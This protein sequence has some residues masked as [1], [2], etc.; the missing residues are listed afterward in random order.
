MSEIL[1]R[2]GGLPGLSGS[3]EFPPGRCF[4][5]SSPGVLRFHGEAVRRSLSSRQTTELLMEDGEPAKNW[6]TLRRLTDAAIEG[7]IR[8]DDFLVAFGGGVVTDVAGFAAAILLRGVAWIAVPTTLLGMADAAIG[9][10]TA[11]DHPLGKNLLGAFHPPLGVLVDPS[12]LETLPP[13]QFRSGLAEV[14][15]AALIGDANAFRAI[16][17]R[18]EAIAASRQVDAAL[19]AA[20]AVKRRIVARDPRDRSERMVLN[21][22]H[23]LGHALERWDGY[24]RFTHGECVCVGM[25]AALDLSADR[26]GFPKAEADLLAGELA[27]FAGREIAQALEPEAPELW[28]ALSRDKKFSSAGRPAVLLARPAEPRIVEVS[29]E[30]WRR[31]LVRFRERIVL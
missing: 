15:K 21:F 9:G 24:R 1:F 10:K 11:I 18:L 31:A 12:L 13:R 22:G 30:E 6:D 2:R 3:F 17:G 25:A 20:V 8:R 4:L 5:V 19:E 16:E 27:A 29:A 23:T 28:E 7:G 14:Y 26:C